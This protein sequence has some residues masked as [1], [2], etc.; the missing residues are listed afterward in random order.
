MT[1]EM[2]TQAATLAG[3]W[4]PGQ[5]LDPV[6]TTPV[7]GQYAHDVAGT[8]SGGWL[9]EYK[10]GNTAFFVPDSYE[11]NALQIRLSISEFSVFG[12]W[13]KIAIS[14]GG[15]NPDP[16]TVT[17]AS[18]I[19]GYLLGSQNRRDTEDYGILLVRV[20]SDETITVE[21]LANQTA[22]PDNPSFSDAA[23]TLKR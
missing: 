4:V 2:K 6:K 10:T 17:P 23:I 9:K 12:V 18:G 20:N 8:L 13:N 3:Y 11:P 15:L 14:S 5:G 1:D 16:T 19:V 21:T 7:L 22:M